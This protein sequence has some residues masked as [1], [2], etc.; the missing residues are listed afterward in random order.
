MKLYSWKNG[1]D[2]SF[3]RTLRIAHIFHRTKNTVD[4][5]VPTIWKL[6]TSKQVRDVRD[7]ISKWKKHT[8]TSNNNNLFKWV[9]FIRKLYHVS[10]GRGCEWYVMWW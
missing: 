5:F 10:S 8:H 9:Y 2:K 7:S 1:N 3:S 4:K 6:I